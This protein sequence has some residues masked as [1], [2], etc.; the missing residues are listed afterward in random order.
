MSTKTLLY[1]ILGGEIVLGLLLKRHH[2]DMMELAELYGSY[3]C[4][5]ME[6]IAK[7]CEWRPIERTLE[8][9]KKKEEE[10]D[11]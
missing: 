11:K 3:N 5:I 10:N 6:K 9:F 4:R 8:K 2:N 1:L 7:C